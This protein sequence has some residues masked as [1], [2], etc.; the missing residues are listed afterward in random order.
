MDTNS[1]INIIW[2]DGFFGCWDHGLLASIFNA[3]PRFVQHNSGRPVFDEA[4]I[5]MGKP[6]DHLAV[7]D[8]LSKFKKALVILT[9]DED[10]MESWK[11]FIPDHVQ[12]WTQ[13]YHENKSPIKDRL[14]LGFPT[15][16]KDVTVDKTLE[17]KYFCS[18][19]GQVQNSHRRKCVDALEKIPGHFMKLASGFGGVNGLEYQ[20]YINILC[21]S[22]IVLCPSGSMCTDS[23]RVY[24]ALECGA[25]PI[26]EP[27]SPRDEKHFNYW[28]EVNADIL[29]CLDDWG[30][31]PFLLQDTQ[32]IEERTRQC[33][34]WWDN[35]KQEFKQKLINALC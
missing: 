35:Y 11:S 5:I 9:S 4:I 10:S 6:Q 20:D 18:F 24:E 27:R 26:V 22:K 32:Y 34:S 7:F 33:L 30:S 13:Y 1:K 15:R 19:V 17:R 31:L 21:Q 25:L 14:L 3:D 2:Y 8:H 16:L 28:K 29:P 23:F 12:V